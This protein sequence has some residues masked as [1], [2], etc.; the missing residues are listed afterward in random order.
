MDDP[1]Q[2]ATDLARELARTFGA[3]LRSALLYGSLARN[4]YVDGVSNINVLVLFEDITPSTLERASPF[5]RRW[6]AVGLVPLLLERDEWARAADVFAIEVLDMLDAHEMLHGEDPL[7]GLEV[8]RDALRLQA[9]RELRGKLVT[10]HS[11][12]LHAAGSTAAMGTLLA[13]AL[14]SLVTYLRAAL[15]LGG[16]DVPPASAEVIEAASTLIGFD[17]AG[18]R[19]ALDA[20]RSR[21]KWKVPITDPVVDRYHTA[22]EQTAMFVD[23][24]GR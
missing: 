16:H 12:M 8:A 24:I 4:E 5:A 22:A 17:P 11:G 18:L 6:A 20:R 21:D 3:E 7:S 9:E 23:R 14:P 10:L 19:A 15:R 13:M 2:A 1:R